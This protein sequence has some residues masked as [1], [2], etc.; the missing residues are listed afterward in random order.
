MTN[1]ADP[2][3]LASSGSTVFAKAG[4]R[5]TVEDA[6]QVIEYSAGGLGLMQLHLDHVGV[7]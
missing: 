5:R 2:D 4:H 1:T 6:L 3:Q 7:S